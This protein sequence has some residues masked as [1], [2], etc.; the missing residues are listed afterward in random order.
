MEISIS[1]T[2]LLLYT[3][4]HYT[5]GWVGPRAGLAGMEKTKIF[6]VRNLTPIS[7]SFSL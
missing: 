2:T 7:W 4:I 1:F 5:E 6:S 3:G